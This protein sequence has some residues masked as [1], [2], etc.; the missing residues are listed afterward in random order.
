MYD[1][2]IELLVQSIIEPDEV[3]VIGGTYETPVTEGLL[4]EDFVDQL[5]VSGTYNDES[6]DREYRSI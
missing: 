4:N 6:F 3:M 2:L 5:K 1:R